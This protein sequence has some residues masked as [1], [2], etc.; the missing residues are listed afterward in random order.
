MI[1]VNPYI[2]AAFVSTATAIIFYLVGYIRSGS[3]AGKLTD[4]V[5]NLNLTVGKL[6]VTVD[7]MKEANDI[8]IE[9]CSRRH[10]T[11]EK[12]FDRQRDIAT[13]RR[14]KP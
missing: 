1:Q 7:A 2:F 10:E 6:N 8:F 5:N 12:E 4:S 14:R 13:N 3:G 9:G 11:I